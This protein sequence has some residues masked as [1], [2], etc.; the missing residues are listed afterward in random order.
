SGNHA[1]IDFTAAF[2]DTLLG[3]PIGKLGLDRRGRLR[4]HHGGVSPGKGREAAERAG[5]TGSGFV[6]GFQIAWVGSDSEQ[7]VMAGLRIT[8]ERKEDLVAFFVGP[9]AE[10]SVKSGAMTLE[11]AGGGTRNGREP[12]INRDVPQKPV[13]FAGETLLGRVSRRS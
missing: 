12:A 9:K 3:Q 4:G 10:G 11:A 6:G 2:A 8:P 5:R 1:A 7:I 13:A